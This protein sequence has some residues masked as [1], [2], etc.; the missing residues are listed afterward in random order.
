MKQTYW[1]TYYIGILSHNVPRQYGIVLL[2]HSCPGAFRPSCDIWAMAVS[3]I[4]HLVYSSVPVVEGLPMLTT[5]GLTS[6]QLSVL[7]TLCTQN[8]PSV[9]CHVFA[10]KSR[11][12]PFGGRD[13]WPWYLHLAFHSADVE[14]VLYMLQC[15]VLPSTINQWHHPIL[16]KQIHIYKQRDIC[17]LDSV[18]VS[19]ALCKPHHLVLCNP[20]QWRRTY[21]PH[22]LISVNIYICWI[23]IQWE[24]SGLNHYKSWYLHLYCI[25]QQ[26]T[27]T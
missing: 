7:F 3:C 2:V 27:C 8:K 14:V 21:I 10:A 15:I 5:I 22:T 1:W 18:C 19:T 6:A 26:L 4:W 13:A 9:N 25:S 11:E 17:P 24:N 23:P 12:I 20:L 16:I